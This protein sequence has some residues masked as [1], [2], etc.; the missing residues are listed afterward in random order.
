M[1]DEQ[2]LVPWDASADPYVRE[3]LSTF[4]YEHLPEHLQVVS[5]PFADLANRLCRQL[6][7]GTQLK[8]GLWDLLRAKDCFVRAAVA[9]H[10]A[11]QSG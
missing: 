9:Q 10:S 11:A 8:H 1:S 5:K 3:I 2:R 4:A 7:P 6:P